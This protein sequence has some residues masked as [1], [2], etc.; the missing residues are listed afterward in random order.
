[1]AANTNTTTSR[2]A[3]TIE[4]LESI[5][6]VVSV[7]PCSRDDATHKL[8]TEQ[9]VVRVNYEVHTIGNCGATVQ[10]LSQTGHY[11]IDVYV[12]IPS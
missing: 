1:M 11:G 3:Q 10:A 9:S 7:H 8:V 4:R 5:A 2:T 6:W 12:T